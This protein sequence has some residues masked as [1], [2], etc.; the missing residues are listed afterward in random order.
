MVFD[1]LFHPILSSPA[2]SHRDWIGTGTDSFNDTMFLFLDFGSKDEFLGEIE[3]YADNLLQS[4]NLAINKR[5]AV[6]TLTS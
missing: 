4:Q 2:N 5:S 1:E 3:V 6:F